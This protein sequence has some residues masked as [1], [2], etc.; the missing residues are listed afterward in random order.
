MSETRRVVLVHGAWHGA[1][2]FSALQH[3]LDELGVPSFAIDLPGHGVS[4][5][6][7]TDLYGDAQHVADVLDALGDPVVLVGHSYGGAVI[8]EAA[9][10]HPDVAHL[11]YLTAF[12]PNRDESIGAVL[13]AIPDARAQLGAAI[14]FRDDGT[15]VLDADSAVPALYGDCPAAAVRAALPR[16]SPQPMGNFAQPVTGSPRDTVASTYVRCTRDLAIHLEHQD[17]MAP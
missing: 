13:A 3:A 17:L 7:L 5:E 8:T 16:L 1:W 10:R 11:V 14:R 2:C 12:A 9:V 15:S 6:P 4:T